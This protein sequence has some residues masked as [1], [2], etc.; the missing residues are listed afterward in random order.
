MGSPYVPLEC[1]QFGHTLR[2]RPGA[3]LRGGD[4]VDCEIR[5]ER[6]EAGVLKDFAVDCERHT[7]VVLVPEPRETAVAFEDQAADGVCLHLKLGRPADEPARRLAGETTRRPLYCGQIFQITPVPGIC[8]SAASAG[9]LNP[10]S[11]SD[12]PKSRIAPYSAT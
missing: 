9:F 3:A 5:V 10:V 4:A 8:T 1:G 7:Y 12:L 11:G 6:G 2:L